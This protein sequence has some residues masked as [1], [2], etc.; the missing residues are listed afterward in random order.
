MQLSP[1]NKFGR[2]PM[3]Q[4]TEKTADREIKPPGGTKGLSAW[5]SV[6]ARYYL[7]PG[8]IRA[9]I[10]ELRNMIDDNKSSFNHPDLSENFSRDQIIKSV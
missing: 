9:Y 6:V 10:S 3:D 2:I 1:V 4:A 8:H 7:T 5:T